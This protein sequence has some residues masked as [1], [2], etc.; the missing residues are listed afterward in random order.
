M[1]RLITQRL[2]ALVG[3]VLAVSVLVFL[4]T[5]L[6][7][8]DPV[9]LI[10]GAEGTPEQYATVESRLGLDRNVVVRYFDWFGDVVRGDLSTSYFSSQPVSER[11]VDGARVTLA[12]VLPAIVISSVLGILLGIVAA[13]RPNGMA[14]RLA[15]FFAS[16]GLATPNFWVGM[17][18]VLL[19]G[20]TLSWLPATGYQ[21]F[22]EGVAAWAES[23]VLPV[24]AM[25]LRPLALIARMTRASLLHVLNQ[26]Y[27]RTAIARGVT[28]R[29][30]ILRHAIRNA[31]VPV[32]TVIGV[33]A[34]FLISTTVVIERVFA[35]P[36][37]GTVAI[38]AVLRQDV[39]VVQ[40][41]VLLVAVFTVLIGLMIDITTAWLNPRVRM[42]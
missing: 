27:I 18:L 13:L 3:V 4:M 14:D 28:R 32:V 21:S 5:S 40:G 12:I 31:M 1:T 2:F 35:L 38:D 7:P 25:S 41:F 30:I 42:S 29:R 39:P 23:L 15:S 22:N 17:L 8:G 16:I 19:F 34:G 33:Q 9:R 11:L 20:V 6:L 37:L 26:E 24:A 36:G 10:I